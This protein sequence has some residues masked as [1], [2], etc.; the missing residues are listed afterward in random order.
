V[1]QSEI[2]V[3][4]LNYTRGWLESVLPRLTQEMLDWAPAEGMR[5]ISGQFI[6]IIS[7]EAP[8]VPAL[9]ENRQISDEEFDL[10]LPDPKSL[11]GLKSSLIEV[12]GRTLA[13]LN[14]LSEDE[15]IEEVS[16]PQWY[17]A[18]W[19]NPFARGEHFRNIAEHEFYHAG[20]LISYLWMRG[21]DPYQW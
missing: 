13:Y 15:L 19:P 18:Y 2:I 7:V 21:D 20:Q 14:S 3:G 16:L 5:T 1:L 6:E 12:R 9:K 17:G 4:R 10:I 11:E 8:L